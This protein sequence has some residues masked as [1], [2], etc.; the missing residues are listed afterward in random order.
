VASVPA[1][2]GI[3]VNSNPQVE[4]FDNDIADNQ[5]ANLIIS[6]YFSTGYMNKTGVAA[7]YDPYPSAIYVYG[8]RF[9]GGGNA[10]DGVKLQALR[11]AVFGLNGHI[12]D[13]LWDGFVDK[14]KLVDGKLDPAR[15]ICI[16]NGDAG[17]L[18]A[19]GP[20]GY[21]NPSTDK[22]PYACTLP[23]LPPVELTGKLAAAA[24][25]S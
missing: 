16:E 3:I 15:A 11:V 4:I 6:S 19:D 23:K 12:S 24:Q 2:T 7:A 25:K 22:A 14:A 1:G 8:N 5:T 21:K 17:V 20:E 13:I 9:S 18:N 10:P